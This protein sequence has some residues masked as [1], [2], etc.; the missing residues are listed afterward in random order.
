MG[1]KGK[2]PGRLQH[3]KHSTVLQSI[4]ISLRHKQHTPEPLSC[5][6]QGHRLQTKGKWDQEENA[7]HKH[8]RMGTDTAHKA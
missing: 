6:H 4:G 7:R 8:G 5:A 3:R 2:V 1:T